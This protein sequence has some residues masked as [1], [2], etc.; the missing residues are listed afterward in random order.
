[1]GRNIFLVVVV[2]IGVCAGAPI[3]A[4]Y[5]TVWWWL[6]VPLIAA[7]TVVLWRWGVDWTDLDDGSIPAKILSVAAL[8]AW[9]FIGLALAVYAA[10]LATQYWALLVV[11]LLVVV[12]FGLWFWV[13]DLIDKA[14]KRAAGAPESLATPSLNDPPKSDDLVR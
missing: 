3:V 5:A 14:R 4:S 8:L 10:M 1:M 6:A 11:A 7:Y 12:A 2:I 13:A 9:S